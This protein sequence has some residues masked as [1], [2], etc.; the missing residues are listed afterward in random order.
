MSI[1]QVRAYRPPPSEN[2][3]EGVWCWVD[4]PKGWEIDNRKGRRLKP[5]TLDQARQVRDDLN[6][7]LKGVE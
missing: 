2:W 7:I 4:F 6:S 5:L 1:D 3:G